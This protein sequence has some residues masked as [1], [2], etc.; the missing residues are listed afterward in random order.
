[1]QATPPPHSG[2]SS[3]NVSGDE[4]GTLSVVRSLVKMRKFVIVSNIDHSG[5]SGGFFEFVF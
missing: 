3:P 1:M 5:E 4:V 2:S